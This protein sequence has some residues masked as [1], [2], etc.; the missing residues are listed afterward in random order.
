[1]ASSGSGMASVGGTSACGDDCSPFC[2]ATQVKKKADEVFHVFSP[3]TEVD[4]TLFA[5]FDLQPDCFAARFNVAYD[6]NHKRPTLAERLLMGAQ[7]D[8]LEPPRP[9]QSTRRSSPV[10]SPMER[11][12]LPF[13]SRVHE[14]SKQMA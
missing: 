10:R 2:L 3:N 1:M 13:R 8:L 9:P 5:A 14:L 11:Y 6:V 7:S 4:R 12:R